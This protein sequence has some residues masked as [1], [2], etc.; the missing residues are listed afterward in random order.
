MNA[1]EA[2]F[3]WLD[4]YPDEKLKQHFKTV[5]GCY[6]LGQLWA[7]KGFSTAITCIAWGNTPKAVADELKDLV[8]HVDAED[9]EKETSKLDEIL[10]DIETLEG[11]GIPF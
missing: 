2:G 3:D 10:E 1:E 9:L 11:L 8:K 7:V 6:A 4:L 5:Y